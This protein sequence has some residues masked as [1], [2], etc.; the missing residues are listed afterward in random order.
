MLAFFPG[1]FLSFLLLEENGVTWLTVPG[2]SPSLYSPPT[3][4]WVFSYQLT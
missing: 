1:V 3:M 4:V 2:S